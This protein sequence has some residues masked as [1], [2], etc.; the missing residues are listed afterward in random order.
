MDRD[1][2]ASTPV[3]PP[4]HLLGFLRMTHR[5]KHRG[6]ILAPKVIGPP[7]WDG[8]ATQSG[9]FILTVGCLMVFGA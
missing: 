6:G 5:G 2:A 9:C 1:L 8:T 3:P 4:T 7:G